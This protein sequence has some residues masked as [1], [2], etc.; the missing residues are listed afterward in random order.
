MNK[1]EIHIDVLQE[2]KNPDKGKI[3]Q[4]PEGNP[5]SIGGGSLLHLLVLEA[6]CQWPYADNI[7][8]HSLTHQELPSIPYIIKW[9]NQG[10]M[11]KE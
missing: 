1:K 10:I 7:Y 6:A 3:L 9:L 2:A 11:P 5:L 8:T 4:I